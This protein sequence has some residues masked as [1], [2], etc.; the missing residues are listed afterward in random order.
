[1]MPDAKGNVLVAGT[2]E[3]ALRMVRRAHVVVADAPIEGN[4]ATFALVPRPMPPYRN[5]YKPGQILS[6][7]DGKAHYRVD[8]KTG[9]F[10]RLDK[11]LSKKARKRGM[12]ANK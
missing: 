2:E 12:K 7:H 6:S 4:T 1:M 11:P 8:E 10:R 3:T 5:R 9:Q